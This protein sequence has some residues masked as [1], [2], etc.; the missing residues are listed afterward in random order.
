MNV[1]LLILISLL[2]LGSLIPAVGIFMATIMLMDNGGVDKKKDNLV[3]MAILLSG[4]YFGVVPI[5]V[6]VAWIAFFIQAYNVTNVAILCP[7]G[8]II[9]FAFFLIRAFRRQDTITK[10]HKS[11]RGN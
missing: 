10:K 6:I 5:S 11:R 7:L 3:W 2:W 9:V 4:A 1:I 8:N